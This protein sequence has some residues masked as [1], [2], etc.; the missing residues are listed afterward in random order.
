MYS[1]FPA[2]C[3]DS[4]VFDTKNIPIPDFLLSIENI[5]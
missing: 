5:N 2:V 1:I 3:E 4:G